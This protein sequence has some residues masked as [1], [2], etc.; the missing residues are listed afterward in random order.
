[1]TVAPIAAFELR[2][3]PVAQLPPPPGAATGAATGAA[4][5]HR[6]RRLASADPGPAD[7][8]HCRGGAA[9]AGDLG[10]ALVGR[11]VLYWCPDDD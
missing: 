8:L 11:I 9:P 10:A 7:W 5:R 2:R 4:H 1:M 3:R 6:R